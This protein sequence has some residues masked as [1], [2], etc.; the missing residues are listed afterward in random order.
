MD[1]C[2]LGI[3][4]TILEMSGIECA[5]VRPFCELQ[6]LR[7]ARHE[8]VFLSAERSRFMIAYNDVGQSK[9]I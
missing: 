2:N 1:C 3:S 8:R 7:R 4:F 5:G 6:I 9:N